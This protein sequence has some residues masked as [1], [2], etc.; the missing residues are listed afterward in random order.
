MISKE[1]MRAE[2][3]RTLR[4]REREREGKKKPNREEEKG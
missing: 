2:A 4:G 3:Q 1:R